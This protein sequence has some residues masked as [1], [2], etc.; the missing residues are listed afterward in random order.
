VVRYEVQELALDVRKRQ[1]GQAAAPAVA[2]RLEDAVEGIAADLDR[3]LA[4]A[5]DEAERRR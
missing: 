5:S 1:R 2:E 4:A 3:V